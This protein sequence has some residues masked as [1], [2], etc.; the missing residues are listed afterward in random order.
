MIQG[1]GIFGPF[2][3]TEG[4][5]I[6]DP[7]AHAPTHATGSSDPI[8]P[9]DIGAEPA[10]TGGT[11]AQVWT[12]IK[13][14]VTRVA[15][16]VAQTWTSLQ[17]FSAGI[18]TG[19]IKPASDSTTA[20]RITKAD[21]T[22]VVTVDTTNSRLLFD[23]GSTLNADGSF[24]MSGTYPSFRVVGAGGSALSFERYQNSSYAPEIV[25]LKG[26]GSSSSPAGTVDGDSVGHLRFSHINSIGNVGTVGE[27]SVV[28]SGI[29]NFRSDMIF[30]TGET[31]SMVE[32]LRLTAENGVVV[33]GDLAASGDIDVGGIANFNGVMGNSTKDPTT[34]APADW[35]QI[36][37]DGTTYYI[38]A[39]AA[40]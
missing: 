13:T 34:D 32:R 39:Y 14:W 4:P 9:G 27:I 7:I 28:R 5:P 12:G 11:S 17:A 40:S 22:P 15:L 3:E 20:V 29:G 19:A 35:V 18:V 38:P 8:E 16:D 2:G 26:R 36:Q 21:E 25:L 31:G 37:I 24:L 10:I 30:S 23:V 6:D 1:D 33:S